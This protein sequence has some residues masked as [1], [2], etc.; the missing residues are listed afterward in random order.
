MTI[1]AVHPMMP[2]SSHDEA[3]EQDFVVAL[4]AF[5]ARELDPLL[6]DLVG[7]IE[8]EFAADPAGDHAAIPAAQATAASRVPLQD[9]RRRAESSAIYRNWVSVNR[10]AQELMWQ[11]AG[12]C[13]DRQLTTLNAKAAAAPAI[14]SLDIDPEFVVP[15]YLAAT[16]THM[17]P[18]S[19]HAT[20]GADDVRQGA[21]FDK[22]AS[23]YSRGRQG[24]VMNDMRGHTVVA[25]VFN[26]FPELA[27]ARI[28]EMGCTV[29]NS[30]VAVAKAFPQAE[31]HGIDVGA[32]LLRYARARAAL[33]GMPLHFS[34]QNAERTRFDDDSFGLVF[35]SAVL[36]ETSARA[37]PRILAECFRVLRPGGVMVHLEVPFRAE[38]A[39]SLSLLKADYET[40]YNNEPFWLGATRADFVALASGAGFVDAATG[41]Q[42]AAHGAPSRAQRLEFG[43]ANKGVYRSWYV[44]SA[45]KPLA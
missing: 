13:V 4:K 6:G 5:A 43:G 23:L 31:V 14:G 16:D 44:A 25:H 37:L 40:R 39:D 33:L 2:D 12:D 21:V 41:Y 34:Q 15:R 32:G 35:T 17:M 8:R 27:P 24:G 45:R 36:H 9:L 19:Y 28:L 42:D 38:T 11:T 1:P 7:D 26:R 18:G 30:L 20:L 3:A 29:G 22:A 10:A